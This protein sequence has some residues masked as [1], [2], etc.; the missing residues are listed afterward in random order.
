M[1]QDVWIKLVGFPER[2]L[3]CRCDAPSEMDSEPR[4]QVDVEPNFFTAFKIA[5]VDSF[6]LHSTTYDAN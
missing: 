4:F 2:V 1:A 3:T 6:D 5:V